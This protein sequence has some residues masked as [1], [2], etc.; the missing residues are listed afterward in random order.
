MLAKKKDNSDRIC[1]DL[2]KLNKQTVKD[3]FPDLL[4]E[5]VLD[6]LQGANVFTAIDL[7]SGFFHVPVEEDSQKYLSFVTH[8]GQYLFTKAPFGFCNSPPVFQRFIYHMFRDLILIRILIV[9]MDDICILAI[10]LEQ[11]IERMEIGFMR[12]SEAGLMINWKKMSIFYEQNRIFGPHHR[13]G[14]N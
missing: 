11:A 9:Y 10:D 14:Y 4:M 5:E 6:D 8:T 2:R 1:V 13:K 3:R 12:A 7:K